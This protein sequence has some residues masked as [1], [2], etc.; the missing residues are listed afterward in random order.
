MNK[1]LVLLALCCPL[2]GA[3]AEEGG[4]GLDTDQKKISYAIGMST[5]QSIVRQGVEID[6]NAFMVGVRD[7][8]GGAP[9]R[10]TQ[11]EFQAAL[12]NATSSVN[13]SLKERARKNLEAGQAYM[14][15][16]KGKDGVIELSNGI[17][18]KELRKGAGAH[19][20]RDDTVVVHYEGRLVDGSVF[21]SSKERGEPATFPVNGVIQGWQ[22]VLPLMAA[23]ARWEVV[24]PPKFAYGVRGAGAGIGPNET[25]VFE[26]E[27]LEVKK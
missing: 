13:N 24:I 16:N 4:V 9:P 8:L 21:D 15:E 25:L 26:I 20:K 10:L 18:Y 3:P 5:A 27:L 2:A 1:K 11:E 14:K 12:S 6:V 19:P 7:A 23:G 17:Q 22:E